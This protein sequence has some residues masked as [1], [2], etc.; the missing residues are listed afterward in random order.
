VVAQLRAEH[1]LR[2]SVVT[3]VAGHRPS[4]VLAPA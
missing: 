2:G 1:A 3:V 4:L